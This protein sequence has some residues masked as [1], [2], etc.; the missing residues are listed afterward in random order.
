MYTDV[1]ST[2]DLQAVREVYWSDLCN[3]QCYIPNEN[4]ESLVFKSS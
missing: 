4:V 2:A 3:I 1:Y